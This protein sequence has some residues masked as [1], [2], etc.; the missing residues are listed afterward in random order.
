MPKL[1]WYSWGTYSNPQTSV[2]SDF[3]IS[4]WISKQNY[5][6]GG[7][8]ILR[9]RVCR[10]VKTPH[11]MTLY[12][13]LKIY[14]FHSMTL[15]FLSICHPKPVFLQFQQQIGYFKWFCAQSSFL[16]LEIN[17]SYFYGTSTS[18]TEKPNISFSPNAPLILDQNAISHSMTP[19]FFNFSSPDAPWCKNWYPATISISY[20]SA[21]P[22]IGCSPELSL[23]S[24]TACSLYQLPVLFCYFNFINRSLDLIGTNK[25]RF[26]EGLVLH[27]D[28]ATMF[29]WSDELI[30]CTIEY[31]N[32]LHALRLDGVEYAVVSALVLTYPGKIWGGAHWC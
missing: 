15:F 20:M 30:Q 16:K 14:G 11:S 26:A 7:T 18:L 17:V 27:A 32:Q 4:N 1:A 13:L 2:M 8:P 3:V 9:C 29:G 23:C 24:T 10:T 6:G 12:F 21:L 22:P 25:I 19:Y 28:E 5:M 31:I